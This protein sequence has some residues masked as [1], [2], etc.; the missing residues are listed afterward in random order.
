MHQDFVK[1]GVSIFIRKNNSKFHEG[2]NESIQNQLLLHVQ[3]RR[4]PGQHHYDKRI[5]LSKSITGAVK[6]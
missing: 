5:L 2:Q 4:Q 3:C 6:C 1:V